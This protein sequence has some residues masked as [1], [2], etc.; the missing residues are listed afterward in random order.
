MPPQCI[1]RCS[2]VFFHLQLPPKSVPMYRSVHWTT[3]IWERQVSHKFTYFLDLQTVSGERLALFLFLD[4]S[5]GENLE[6][7]S[8]SYYF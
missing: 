2:C 4:L 5:A 6:N 3:L 8:T 7:F 1:P